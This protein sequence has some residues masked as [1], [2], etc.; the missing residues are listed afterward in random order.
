MA[1]R[2]MTDCPHAPETRIAAQAWE[3]ALASGPRVEV[4]RK[5]AQRTRGVAASAA[6]P[7]VKLAH[8]WR[9]PGRT[10]RG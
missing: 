4:K 6:H 7:L 1:W 2:G 5:R 10:S 3:N 9:K 8:A